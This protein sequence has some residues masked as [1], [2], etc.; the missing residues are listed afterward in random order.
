MI[1]HDNNEDIDLY[2]IAPWIAGLVISGALIAVMFG[3]AAGF[4]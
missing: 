1:G 4:A 2:G 3:L